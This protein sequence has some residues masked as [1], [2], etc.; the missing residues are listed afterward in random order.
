MYIYNGIYKWQNRNN[1][2]ITLNFFP[3][4]FEWNSTNLAAQKNEIFH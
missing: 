3:I 2:E 4:Y 1:M